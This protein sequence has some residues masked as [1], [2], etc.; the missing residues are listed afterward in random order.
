MGAFRIID[1]CLNPL[2]KMNKE[3]T[4]C[5][6]MSSFV[7]IHRSINTLVYGPFAQADIDKISHLQDYRVLILN[8]G[9]H[10]LKENQTDIKFKQTKTCVVCG[11][12][13]AR[14]YIFGGNDNKYCSRLCFENRD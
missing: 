2:I 14:A 11:C 4:N 12:N 10:F 1:I 9:S 5:I 3:L 13:F 6:K 7:L 8:D